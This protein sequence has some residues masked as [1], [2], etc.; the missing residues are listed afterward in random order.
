MI[1]WLASLCVLRR[2]P[3]WTPSALGYA[4]GDKPDLSNMVCSL[5]LLDEHDVVFLMSDGVA[6]NFDPFMLKMARQVGAPHTQS[7]RCGV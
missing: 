7:V 1:I 4:L 5:S 6:D 3:R 2:D